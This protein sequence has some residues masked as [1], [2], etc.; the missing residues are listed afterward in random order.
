MENFFTFLSSYH[1]HACFFSMLSFRNIPCTELKTEFATTL[2]SQVLT[3]ALSAFF[4]H[5][6]INNTDTNTS[7]EAFKGEHT[8]IPVA[9]PR[10][11]FPNPNG[12]YHKRLSTALG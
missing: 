6:Y 2:L 1:F 11:L 10:V 12:E 8:I 9:Y 4:E 7:T 5:T 3:T